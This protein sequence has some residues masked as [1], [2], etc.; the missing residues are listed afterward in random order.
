MMRGWEIEASRTWGSTG[1]W[2]ELRAA[3][4]EASILGCD[5]LLARV[6]NGAEAGSF[7]TSSEHEQKTVRGVELHLNMHAGD[8]GA[9]L[10]AKLYQ[11]GADIHMTNIL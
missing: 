1:E 8:T 2:S 6:Y 10:T 5:K 9:K 11:L 7:I 4:R 3:L